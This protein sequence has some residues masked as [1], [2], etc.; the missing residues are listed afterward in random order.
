MLWPS[1]TK[2]QSNA[3][4]TLTKFLPCPK[5]LYLS[6]IQAW[7]PYL[8]DLHCVVSD[9]FIG[10]SYK[11]KPSV[12]ARPEGRNGMVR[13]LNK[14]TCDVGKYIISWVEQRTE[15]NKKQKQNKQII[16]LKIFLHYDR[17]NGPQWYGKL[18]A[19][20]H[21]GWLTYRMLWYPCL[22][23]FSGII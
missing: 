13:A 7:V 6:F 20:R 23:L 4:Q 2:R 21:C 16:I 5:P 11:H 17:C 19:F 22:N 1:W 15:K 18:A 9:K 10:L 14:V 8:R 3:S 12:Q